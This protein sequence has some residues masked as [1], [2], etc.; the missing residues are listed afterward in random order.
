MTFPNAVEV[1]S[2]TWTSMADD[3]EKTFVVLELQPGQIYIRA[4][5]LCDITFFE[6]FEC[7]NLPFDC[8]DLTIKIEGQ[9]SKDVPFEFVPDD[10]FSLMRS[11]VSFHC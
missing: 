11:Q 3:K 7:E 8:Q 9:E 6:D 2:K 5:L 1:H 10:I 4:V